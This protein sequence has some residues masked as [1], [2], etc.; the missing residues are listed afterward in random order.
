MAKDENKNG[1]G[2][3]VQ[4]KVLKEDDDVVLAF[5]ELVAW[6]TLPPLAAIELADAMKLRAEEILRSDV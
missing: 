1:T 4:V 2:R 3:A 6:V 5:G